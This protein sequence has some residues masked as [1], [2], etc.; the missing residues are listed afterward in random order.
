MTTKK[1]YIFLAE[2]LK[3][4]KPIPEAL[5]FESRWLAWYKSTLAI[6]N[7]C[8]QD[9]PRFDF[10]KFFNACG[11]NVDPKV[12]ELAEAVQAIKLSK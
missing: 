5:H 8:H 2:A 1:T 9:N 6:A 11:L 7:A 12:V 4:S 3:W 10:N